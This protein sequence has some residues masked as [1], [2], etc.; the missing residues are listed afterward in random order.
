MTPT[1]PPP[2]TMTRGLLKEA[3]QNSDGLVCLCLSASVSVCCSH[4]NVSLV[5]LWLTYFRASVRAQ[6]NQGR[7]GS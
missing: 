3:V 5:D 7:G 6:V 4:K 2:V 1:H